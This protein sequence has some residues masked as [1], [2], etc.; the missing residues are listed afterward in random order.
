M[1]L[2][3]PLLALA[4][5]AFGIGVTEFSPMGMLSVIAGDLDVSIPTAGVLISAYA[6]GVVIGAPIMTLG[7]ARM[8]RRNLLLLSMSIFTVGNLISAVADSYS[9]L[10][11]GRIITSF[12][13][14]AF[15]G[16]GAVVA[17]QLVPPEK[18]ASAVAAM[19][20]GLTI[21]NIGGVPL[22]TYVS[23]VMGW[24]TAFMGMTIIG[25]ATLIALRLSL[26][27]LEADTSGSIKNELKVLTKGSVLFALLLTVVGSSS[28]FTVFSYISPILLEETKADALFVS[29]MLVLYGLGLAAGN[30]LAGRYAD[31]NLLGTLVISMAATMILLMIFAATMQVIWVM[32]VL[33]F[34]WGISSFAVV[35]PLQA[36]VVSEAKGAPNLASSMNIAAFNLGNA[37]GAAL[38]GSVI[39]L[40]WG[41]PA[42]ALAGAATSAAGLLLVLLY[43]K[44]SKRSKDP[45][46]LSPQS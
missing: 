27:R 11:L 30:W 3:L 22:A 24:R 10:L 12:N 33:I 43:R 32:P 38:G 19:F 29:S 23:E 34:L 37:S 25:V 41:L 20:S 7:F 15:F 42:V 5:G 28:M 4:L 21:A 18:Q 16:I 31:R 36:L 39:Y 9:S 17:T 14:G 40:G 45:T 46:T 8:S 6:F 26:P 35:P 44:Q 13:H 2:N 1:K